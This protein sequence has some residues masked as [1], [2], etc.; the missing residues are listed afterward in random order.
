M[1]EDVHNEL[2][3]IVEVE[4]GKTPEEAKEYLEAM[5]KAKRYKRDV[6]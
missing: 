1:A 3:R 2:L 4:G 6:Y 5:K